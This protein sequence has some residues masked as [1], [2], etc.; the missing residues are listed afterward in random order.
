MNLIAFSPLITKY[1]DIYGQ[2]KN[3][4][5]G[6]SRNRFCPAGEKRAKICPFRTI[7]L[8][9]DPTSRLCSEKRLIY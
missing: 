7:I 2:G 8:I 9:L 1:H 5:R 3:A 6:E 4:A